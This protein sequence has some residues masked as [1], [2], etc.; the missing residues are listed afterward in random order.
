MCV[1]CKTGIDRYGSRDKDYSYNA[2]HYG[3]SVCKNVTCNGTQLLPVGVSVCI[4]VCVHYALVS[5]Q[6]IHI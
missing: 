4:C 5:N 1:L 6:Q 2:V 3:V